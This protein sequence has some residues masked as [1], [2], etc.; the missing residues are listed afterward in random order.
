MNCSA[1]PRKIIVLLLAL[2]HPVKKLYLSP[3]TCFSSNLSQ[4]PRTF[5]ERSDSEVW[6]IAP[7]AL[8]TRST[9]SLGP[10]P[11]QNILRSA[12]YWV[13]KSPMGNLDKTIW[14]PL[15]TIFSNL[16]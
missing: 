10:R 13:A 4:R 7:V 9:S 3:P 14:A 11:A 5:G 6:I 2:G 15:L 16:S 1:P 8:E 12:K